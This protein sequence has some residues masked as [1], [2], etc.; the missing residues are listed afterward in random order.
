M[1]YL[2]NSFGVGLTV[3]GQ[4]AEQVGVDPAMGLGVQNRLEDQLIQTGDLAG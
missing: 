2:A 1:G 3:G 4:G